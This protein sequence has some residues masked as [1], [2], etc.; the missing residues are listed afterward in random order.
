M[1]QLVSKCPDWI[2]LNIQ[3]DFSSLNVGKH[4]SAIDSLLKTYESAEV[5]SM[6]SVENGDKPKSI[7]IRGKFGKTNL[8]KVSTGMKVLISALISK[9]ENKK[10]C[11]PEFL[12]GANYLPALNSIASDCDLISLWAPRL[13]L[14]AHYDLRKQVSVLADGEVKTI[15]F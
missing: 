12:I 14:S 1:L 6:D 5:L 3:H 11:C 4:I 9:F 8:D 7:V 13:D 2:N 10:F 15:C